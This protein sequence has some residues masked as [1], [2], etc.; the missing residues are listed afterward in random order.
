MFHRYRQA[1]FKI[2]KERQTILKKR[3]IVGGII[4]LNFSTYY[5]AVIVKTG[6]YC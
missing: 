1:D 3:N 2:Y 4:P 6:R 5:K